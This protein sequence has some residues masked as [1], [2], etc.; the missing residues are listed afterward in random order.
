MDDSVITIEGELVLVKI[1]R[2]QGF[3][4]KIINVTPDPFKK[5]WWNV[6][7]FPLVPTKEFK[8]REASWKLDEDQIRGAEFTMNHIPHQLFKV[9]Y[10]GIT[11]EFKTNADSPVPLPK[12]KL[13]KKL[14]SSFL[15]T[16][17]IPGFNEREPEKPRS[18]E[19]SYLK[20]VK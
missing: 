13:V 19:R 15:K 14:D 5:S 2:V 6:K 9:E 18:F 10:E 20:L 16:E 7:F 4:I 8:L 11:P 17:L 12:P 3:Y 1:N